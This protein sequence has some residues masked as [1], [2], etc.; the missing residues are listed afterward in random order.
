MSTP[1]VS[2]EA[3]KVLEA[4]ANP[5]PIKTK[6][7]LIPRQIIETLTSLPSIKS[8]DAKSP[9]IYEHEEVLALLISKAEKLSSI[10]WAE[11]VGSPKISASK[12]QIAIVD[13]VGQLAIVYK[14]IIDTSNKLIP[15][16]NSILSLSNIFKGKPGGSRANLIKLQKEG[17]ILTKNRA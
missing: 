9:V 16:G 4:L 10:Q 17:L 5:K 15:Q 13:K 2:K 8:I 14:E 1:Q 6:K 12:Y 7:P 11:L 3:L